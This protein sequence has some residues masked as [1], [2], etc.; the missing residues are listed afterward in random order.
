MNGNIRTIASIAGAENLSDDVVSAAKLLDDGQ[1]RM[2]SSLNRAEYFK[3]LVEVFSKGLNQDR[4]LHLN[5]FYIIVPALCASHVD[6]LLLAKEKLTKRGKDS[7]QA[8]FTE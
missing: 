4:N 5:D 7:L 3:I 1:D 2:Q 6:A 8:G